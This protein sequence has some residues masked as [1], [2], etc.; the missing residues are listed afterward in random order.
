MIS[1]EVVGLAKFQEYFETA[2]ERSR[3]AASIALN[4]V[5]ARTVIPKSRDLIAE[6]INFP[7]GYLN[8]DRLFIK[9][10]SNPTTLETIITGRD[11]PTSLL[12]FST[13]GAGRSIA[14]TSVKP[15]SARPVRRGFVIN[16][17]SGNQGYAIRLKPGE[18]INRSVAATRLE[19]G[20]YLLYGPSVNQAFLSVASELTPVFLDALTDEFLRQFTRD[21]L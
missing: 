3:K 7:A 21:N 5:A 15:G 18:T 13:L 19:K 2:G 10:P 20:L 12:R 1:L 9:S 11:R 6:Q 17:S 16:L 14:S 8:G 4:Q